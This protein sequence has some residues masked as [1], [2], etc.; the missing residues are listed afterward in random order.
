MLR[1]KR[2]IKTRDFWYSIAILFI[3][4]LAIFVLEQALL[5]DEPDDSKWHSLFVTG[6]N[7]LFLGIVFLASVRFGFKGGAGITL[8]LALIQ[9]PH[10]VAETIMEGRPENLAEYYI[11]IPIAFAIAL[12]VD[13]SSRSKRLLRD[14][15]NRYRTLYEQSPVGISTANMETRKFEYANPAFCQIL[16]YTQEEL[17]G[18]SVMDIHPKD[19]LDKV[20]DNFVAQA[21]GEKIDEPLPCLRKDG[22]ILQIIVTAIPAVIDGRKCSIG[23]FTDV[24]E[25][26]KLQ[27]QLMAQDRLASIGQLVSGVAHELNNPM[28]SVVGFSD[29]LLQRDLPSDVKADLEIVNSEAKRTAKIVQNLLT[30]S[31]Q[32]NEPT[33]LT[34]VWES[35]D[36]VLAVRSHEQKINNITVH[37]VHPE[38][39]YQVMASPSQL[40]QV[41]FN[42]IVNA[43]QAILEAKKQGNITITIVKAGNMVRASVADDGPGI[44]PE[45]MKRLFTP[46]FTTKEIGKGTGLGL[47]I[48]HGFVTAIGGRIFAESTLGKGATF[49]VELPIANGNTKEQANG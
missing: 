49:V 48:I 28:T 20:R 8:A 6:R 16:G 46:F 33:V 43:E 45:N 23:F 10:V 24:T 11:Y 47:S 32:R 13:N 27:E 5:G 2:F 4:I 39:T 3:I 34:S 30:F 38:A 37:T 29:I 40:Q 15:E 12:L 31:R 44:S 7:F 19:S 14:S 41:F 1:T 17:A 36:R 42:L 35:V 9:M 25:S 21:R 18:M 26:R 22:S